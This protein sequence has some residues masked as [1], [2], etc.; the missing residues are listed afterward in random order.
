MLSIDA[1]LL[2]LGIEKNKAFYLQL[3]TENRELENKCFSTFNSELR[4]EN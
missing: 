2:Q 1:F 4:T 3:R